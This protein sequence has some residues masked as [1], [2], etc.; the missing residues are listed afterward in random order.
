MGICR[1]VDFPVFQASSP[2][3]GIISWVNQPAF[4]GDF[5]E[6]EQEKQLVRG[7]ALCAIYVKVGEFLEY[8]FHRK[9]QFRIL[10]LKSVT[11]NTQL[12]NLEA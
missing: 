3:I 12:D 6:A 4:F 10:L 1:E 11:E 7:Y 2:L 5:Q 9:A 8:I